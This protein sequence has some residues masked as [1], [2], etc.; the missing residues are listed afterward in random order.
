MLLELSDWL[1]ELSFELE[2]RL[3][4]DSKLEEL[5]DDELSRLLEDS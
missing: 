4:E 5:L 2:L 3:L 1:D